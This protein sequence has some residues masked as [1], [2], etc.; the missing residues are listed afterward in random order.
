[1]ADEQPT[2]G[3]AKYDILG[4]TWYVYRNAVGVVVYVAMCDPRDARPIPE[5]P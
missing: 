2:R 5:R 1:M 4:R 3:W